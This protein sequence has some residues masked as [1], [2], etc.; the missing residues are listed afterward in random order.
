VANSASSRVSE[1]EEAWRHGLGHIPLA[2]A[3]EDELE[4]S[5]ADG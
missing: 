1:P 3:E 4:E 5:F 2:G